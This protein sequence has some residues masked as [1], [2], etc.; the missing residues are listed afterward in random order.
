VTNGVVDRKECWIVSIP[1]SPAALEAVK[2][3]MESG[4]QKDLLAAAKIKMSAVPIPTK[5]LIFIDKT[6]LLLN[7]QESLDGN[8]KVIQSITYQNMQPNV[9][10]SDQLFKLPD[11]IKIEDM[12]TMMQGLLKTEEQTK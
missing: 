6:T 11:N 8:E 2:K 3:E 12:G 9:E 4:P 7:K 10:I 5:T 1:T